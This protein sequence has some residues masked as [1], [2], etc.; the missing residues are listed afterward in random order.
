[1]LKQVATQVSLHILLSVSL[2]EDFNFNKVQCTCFSLY[3][4]CFCCCIS[5]LTNKPKFT[6]VFSCSRNFITL[7]VT[8]QTYLVL[9]FV[10]VSCVRRPSVSGPFVEKAIL[11]PLH[12]LRS[13]V[14]DQFI[15][16][17]WV[18]WVFYSTLLTIC[19]YFSPLSWCH[20]YFSFI[21]LKVR[22]Y[23][24]PDFVV[25]FFRVVPVSLVCL[26]CLHIQFRSCLSISPK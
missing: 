7:Q 21:S 22:W 20:D 23:P 9:I 17:V 25:V 16:C 5:K 2:L 13:F 1:M 26:L 3:G 10:N 19:L 4:V 18:F 14:K 12:C 15:I 6:Q 8:F 24:P 11:S